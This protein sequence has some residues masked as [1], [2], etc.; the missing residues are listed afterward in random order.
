MNKHH[1]EL[2]ASDREYLEA[3]IAKGTLP[4]KGYRRAVALLA[5]DTGQTYT[6]VAQTVKVTVATLSTLA[7]RYQAH[8]LQALHDQRRSGRPLEIDGV[9]RAKI[10]ALACSEPPE[11]YAQWSFRLLADRA[12]ELEF[13]DHLSHSAV[14]TILKKTH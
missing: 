7:Q 10:T 5:L 2:S 11:G 8:G 6:T 12:V 13:C 9:Q 14:R 4:V 3:L 1:V